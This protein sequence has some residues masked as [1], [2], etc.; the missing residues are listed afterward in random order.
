M[1]EYSVVSALIERAEQEARGAGAS[2]IARLVVRIGESSGVDAGLLATAFEL[3]REGTM[4][5]AAEL[6]IERVAVVWACPRCGAT[7]SG[8]GPLRCGDCRAAAALRSGDELVLARIEA[9]VPVH[10]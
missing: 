8:D 10:V 7:I 6:E 3:A 1:H 2:S 4:C 9:E 5:A